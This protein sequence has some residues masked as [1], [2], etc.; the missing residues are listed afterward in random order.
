M[1][2][3]GEVDVQAD[4]T[5]LWAATRGIER[6]PDGRYPVRTDADPAVR[7]GLV[8]YLRAVAVRQ[9]LRVDLRVLVTS[10]TP[11]TAVKWS[12]VAR[13]EG[14]LFSLRTMDPGEAVVRQRLAVD[15][16]VSDQCEEAVR[17]WYG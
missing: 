17:R 9:A 3:A 14:A 5:A 8:T 2:A 16:V 10:G 6:E 4:Y 13:E 15:G 7:S 1:L 12:T 11:K